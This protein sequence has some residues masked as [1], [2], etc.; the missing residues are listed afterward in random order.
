MLFSHWLSLQAGELYRTRSDGKIR[1]AIFHPLLFIA[2][3]VT[4]SDKSRHSPKRISDGFS[5]ESS[6]SNRP[7]LDDDEVIG[8]CRIGAVAPVV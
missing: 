4:L 8:E 2:F 6:A 5:T 7:I 1:G 3:V